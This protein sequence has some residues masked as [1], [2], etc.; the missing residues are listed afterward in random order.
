LELSQ[1]NER[2]N[3]VAYQT[4]VDAAIQMGRYNFEK[5]VAYA[6]YL[7]TV[8]TERNEVE[9]NFLRAT[10]DAYLI[11]A[12]SIMALFQPTSVPI[13][14]GEYTSTQKFINPGD[15]FSFSASSVTTSGSLFQSNTATL[16]GIGSG[17]MHSGYILDSVTVNGVTS[18]GVTPNESATLIISSTLAVNGVTYFL[19]SW[20]D[21]LGAIQVGRDGNSTSTDGY[22]IDFNTGQ[23]EV[24]LRWNNIAAS[25]G[26]DLIVGDNISLTYT[27]V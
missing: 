8:Q 3:L 6:S 19:D 18:S 7:N 16:T 9:A 23:D 13:N 11:K 22:Q 1:Y 21:N 15:V 10:S 14:Y 25:G 26:F 12:T 4:N 24:A 2:K 5:D 27:T 17:L 20:I